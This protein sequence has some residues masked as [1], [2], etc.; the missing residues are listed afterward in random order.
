MENFCGTFESIVKNVEKVII[1]KRETIELLLIAFFCDGHV[2]IE[3]IPGVGKT[4]L[5]SAVSRSVQCSFRRIQFTPDVLPSD[6]TGFYIYNQKSGEFEFR[7]GLV[8]SNIILADEINRTPP[9]TQASLLEVM[10]ERQVTVEG[11]TFKLPSPFMVIATQNP[12]EYLGTYPLPEAQIDR[13]FLKLSMGYP[14]IEEEMQMLARF[15]ETSPLFELGPVVEKEE[16]IKMQAQ[17]RQV[18]V[19]SSISRYIIEIINKTRNHND[20]ILGASPRA[21]LCL[22]RGA[23]GWALRQGRNYVLPDDVKKLVIPV[24]SHRLML[25]QEAKIKRI[26]TE[27]I[28]CDMLHSVKIPSV[29]INILDRR[30]AL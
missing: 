6:I 22:Y 11:N 15:K 8:M 7:K 1:G 23:Q 24:L 12:A 26:S 19:D 17:V 16:I 30:H 9:R 14:Q 2:I 13:F 29:N 27:E 4:S 20:I 10:E 25:K 28:L 5:A 18:Y 3:D 21:S